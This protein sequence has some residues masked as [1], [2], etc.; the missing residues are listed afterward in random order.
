MERFNRKIHNGA[1]MLMD[2]VMLFSV[3]I[4]ICAID[5]NANDLRLIISMI[6]IPAIWFK[7]RE[8]AESRKRR[9]RS[10]EIL[11]L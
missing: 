9:M 4:A 3:L 8:L 11:H 6:T 5:C 1:L 7:V 10:D 2:G